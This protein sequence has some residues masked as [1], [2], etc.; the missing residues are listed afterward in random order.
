MSS[1]DDSIS[2]TDQLVKGPE[3]KTQLASQSAA[4]TESL[5]AREKRLAEQ[6]KRIEAMAEKIREENAK[7]KAEVKTGSDLLDSYMMTQ[8]NSSSSG[9]PVSDIAIPV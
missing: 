2:K 6:E 1:I 4:T 3:A 5:D 9:V 7:R 8:K